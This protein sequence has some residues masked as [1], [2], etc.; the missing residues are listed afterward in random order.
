MLVSF[1]S[2][3]LR[4]RKKKRRGGI[5]ILFFLRTVGK[6]R[7]WGEWCV[8]VGSKRFQVGDGE[9]GIESLGTHLCAVEDGV[10]LVQLH[11]VGVEVLQP[12]LPLHITGVGHP[13]VG[14]EKGSRAQVFVVATLTP[15]V[16]GTGG[17]AARTKNALVESIEAA[18]VGLGLEGLSSSIFSIRFR[19]FQPGA[20]RFVLLIEVGEVRDQISDHWQVW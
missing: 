5:R 4:R 12:F 1:S 20:D 2:P 14:L 17:G 16:A 9:S 13:P 6:G 11:V 10:T 18:S 3:P 15:P 8:F 19:Q 7:W